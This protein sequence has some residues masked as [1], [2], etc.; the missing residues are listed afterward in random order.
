[1]ARRLR[2]FNLC[3]VAV[4]VPAILDCADLR[5]RAVNGIAARRRLRD[6]SNI[7]LFRT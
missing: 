4:R 5:N 2:V 6:V 1:M 7:S 3:S